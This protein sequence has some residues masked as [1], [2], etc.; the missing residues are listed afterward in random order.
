[1]N[2]TL[3]RLQYRADG[4]FGDL[5]ADDGSLIAQTLEHAYP[6]LPP[7]DKLFSPKIPKGE[8]TCRR[9]LSPH[10]KRDVFEV[11]CVPECTYIEIHWGNFD[12]DSEGCILLGL[13]LGKATD[14]AQML[15]YSRQAFDR[16]MA[17]QAG[18]NEF[19]LTVI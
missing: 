7:D 6:C 9:R 8:Y 19:T 10:F 5:R 18:V 15:T 11:L 4:V 12:N 13:H 16:F 17:L 14:G 2:C 1:M 3:K